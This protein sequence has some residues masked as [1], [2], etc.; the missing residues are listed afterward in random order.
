VHEAAAIAPSE[1]ESLADATRR[2]WENNLSPH[3]L[4]LSADSGHDC[5]APE[6]EIGWKTRAV[7]AYEVIAFSPHCVGDRIFETA[8]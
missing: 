8:H 7:E 2:V 1:T 4:P 3:S 5:E 6:A